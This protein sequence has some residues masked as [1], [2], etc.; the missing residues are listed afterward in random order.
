MFWFFSGG[1]FVTY[2][3]K[4]DRFLLIGILHGAFAECS[5]ELP[6][7]FTRIDHYSILKFIR[8]IVF[9]EDIGEGTKK[10]NSMII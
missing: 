6:A 7:I 4:E 1:P 10:L 5:N 3:T 8:K 2:L 9:D